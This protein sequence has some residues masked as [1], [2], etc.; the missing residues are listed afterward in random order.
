MLT[1]QGDAHLNLFLGFVPFIVFALLT[2]LS[3]DLALWTA[4][5]M[6][7]AI[8]MRGFLHAREVRI[9]DVGNIVMF[10]F[11]ALFCGFIEPELE[12]SAIRLVV[13]VALVGI[14][15]ASLVGRQP[16]TLQYARE[17]VAP[18]ART[19]SQF[20]RANYVITF[21]WMVAFALMALADGAATFNPKVTITEAVGAGLLSLAGAFAFTW[22]YPLGPRVPLPAE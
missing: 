19:A 11:L 8:G 22:R 15:L 20:I 10:G 17:S 13:D 18:A 4:F 6:A 21:V 2:R 5:G 14:A 1:P 12:A 3:V 7:F 16:F 9:L